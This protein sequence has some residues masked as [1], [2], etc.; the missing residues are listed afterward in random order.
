VRVEDNLGAITVHPTGAPAITHTFTTGYVP[1]P[2]KLN[3]FMASNLTTV[4]D[5]HGDFDD[6]VE[7]WNASNDTL[8]LGGM[9]LT[10]N[11]LNPDKWM[12]PEVEILPGDFLLVWCDEEPGEGALHTSFKLAATGEEIGL[13]DSELTGVGLIDT[14]TF[15]QQSIDVSFG[16]FPD[17]GPWRVLQ[18]PTPGESNG[19]VGVGED[20]A[21]PLVLAL[22]GPFPNPFNPSAAFELDLPAAGPVR[23][24]IHDVKGR[25][26]RGLIDEPLP[27]GRHRATWDGRD[28]RGQRVASGVYWFRLEAGGEQRQ[29]RAVLLR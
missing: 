11:L 29:T 9:F 6:W 24:R 26:V 14:V 17:G 23:L 3:E 7:L 19:G 22:R 2:L 25:R 28:D 20:G 13:F 15:G 1:P 12:F 10:D 5:E 4:A 18:T 8:S 16:R 21:P 27:A